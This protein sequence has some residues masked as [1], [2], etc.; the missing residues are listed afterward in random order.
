M[1][2]GAEIKAY[3]YGIGWMARH[4]M[5]GVLDHLDGQDDSQDLGSL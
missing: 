4:W 5:D 1:A 2:K 3:A